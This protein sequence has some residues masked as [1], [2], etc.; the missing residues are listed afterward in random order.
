MGEK[1]SSSS[2]RIGFDP[3]GKSRG[4]K[5]VEDET[6]RNQKKGSLVSI[7]IPNNPTINSSDSTQFGAFVEALKT[8]GIE[9]IIP[10]AGSLKYQR[11]GCPVLSTQKDS[12]IENNDN[13]YS[14]H[15][16]GGLFI[17]KG[18]KCYTY[19]RILEDLNDLL[20]VGLTL[21]SK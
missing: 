9:R 3:E 21:V 15:Q 20:N 18:C 19:I 2:A 14:Y 5:E 16:E 13:G 8:I 7:Q 6:A 11:L 4:G 10:I 17:I 12:R 1:E